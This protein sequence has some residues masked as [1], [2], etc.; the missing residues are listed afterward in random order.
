L[1]HKQLIVSQSFHT[2]DFPM[3]ASIIFFGFLALSFSFALASDPSP[4]QDFC[5]AGG[6]GN[7]MHHV[8]LLF[9]LIF[10]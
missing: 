1:V 10:S 5:V 4:L 7:G 6:D 3:A 9:L 2:F 8:N